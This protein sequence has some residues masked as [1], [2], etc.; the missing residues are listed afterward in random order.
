MPLSNSFSREHPVGEPVPCPNCQALLRLP[1]GATTVRCPSCKAV[2]EIDPGD[3]PAPPP[4]ARRATAI[5]LP[6]GRPVPPPPARPA[7]AVPAR[8]KAIKARV[9]ADD[10]YSAAPAAVE[11]DEDERERDIRRQL[12]ELDAE[13]RRKDARFDVLSGECAQ[14]RTGL[15]LVAVGAIFSLLSAL[16]TLLFL[17]GGVIGGGES[18]VAFAV[19]G[20]ALLLIHWLLNVT[21]LGFCLGGPREARGT[22]GL[23][24]AFTLGHM[25]FNAVATFACVAPSVGLDMLRDN[26]RGDTTLFATLMIGN[27]VSN[28]TVVSDLPYYALYPSHVRPV[29][30]VMLLIAA[31]FEFAKLSA[32]ALMANQYATLAKDP[33]LAHSGMRFVYRIF[34]VVLLGPAVKWVCA[35][36]LA[37]GVVWIPMILASVAYCLWWSFAWAAQYR[38]LLD[39]REILT[40]V[41]LMDRRERYDVV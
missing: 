8:S 2:L 28:L 19:L 27:C 17:F 16:L 14:A 20:G 37:A 40:A 35:L 15:T 31:G 32:I 11:L 24:I 41:R 5:P 10:P 36:T 38:V 39:I 12:R 29:A 18:V 26:D 3:E 23:G 7:P 1:A 9:V 25:A 21:G 34:G 22:A 30:V 33:D 6:F 4:P 13:A